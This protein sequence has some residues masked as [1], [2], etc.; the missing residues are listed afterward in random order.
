MVIIIPVQIPKNYAAPITC[1]FII[2]HA[3]RV[4][5]HKKTA[6]TKKQKYRPSLQY[7]NSGWR[8]LTFR[9]NKINCEETGGNVICMLLR[10]VWALLRETK[11]E[12]KHFLRWYKQGGGSAV[13]AHISGKP[14]SSSAD[15]GGGYNKLYVDYNTGLCE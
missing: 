3:K 5:L 13:W 4:T 8:W 1:L 11:E 12:V 2:E 7:D 14:F 6:T 10:E 15:N 9:R